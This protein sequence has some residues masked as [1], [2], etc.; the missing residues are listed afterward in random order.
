MLY[1]SKKNSTH[2]LKSSLTTIE[3]FFSEILIRVNRNCLVNPKK[4]LKVDKPS[5]KTKKN[6]FIINVDGEEISVSKNN[7]IN[8]PAKFG[9]N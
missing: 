2:H 1:E 6:N 4:I 5:G 9:I 8:F 3:C 7:I